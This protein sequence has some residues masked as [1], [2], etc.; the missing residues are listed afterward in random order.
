M[1]GPLFRLVCS[2][3]ILDGAPE[4]WVSSML[5]EGE[6]AL[7]VDD[8]GLN[9]ISAVAHR[10]DLVTVPLLR[11]EDS[12]EQQE[13]TIMSYAGSMALVWVAPAFG[14][15]ATTGRTTAAR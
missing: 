8:G 7:L 9:A 3:G 6:L 10:L 5:E 1:V 2:P 14:D 13:R 11:T 12:A 15:A 4:G